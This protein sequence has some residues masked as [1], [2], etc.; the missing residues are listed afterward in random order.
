MTRINESAAVDQAIR[1][2]AGGFQKR[3]TWIWGTDGGALADSFGL[4]F[5]LGYTNKLLAESMSI[6]DSL[7]AGRASWAS[8]VTV[9]GPLGR[10]SES[11]YTWGDASALTYDPLGT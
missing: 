1:R 2:K 3:A 9:T 11:L 8:R 4:V 10:L 5:S 7:P 6:A